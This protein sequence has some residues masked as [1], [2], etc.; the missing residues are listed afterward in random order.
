MRY[1]LELVLAF[2]LVALVMAVYPSLALKENGAA[3]A[4]ETLTRELLLMASA[5]ACGLLMGV[6]LWLNIPILQ[7]IFAPIA[8][9]NVQVW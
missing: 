8:P 1:R 3:Q 7:S 2:P 5:I 4:H 9:T 6:L